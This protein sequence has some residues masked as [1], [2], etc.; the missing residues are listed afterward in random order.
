MEELH[1]ATGTS[2][3]FTRKDG[4]VLPTAA[5]GKERFSLFV[6]AKCNPDEV[7]GRP[8]YV[9]T[10]FPAASRM[11]RDRPIFKTWMLGSAGNAVEG[12]SIVTNPARLDMD[13]VQIRR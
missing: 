13:S 10:L 4:T 11:G 8:S 9:K 6:D 3:N 7:T 12:S 5:G 1:E 2:A